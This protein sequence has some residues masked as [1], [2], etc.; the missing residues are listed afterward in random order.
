[1]SMKFPAF[2][3]AIVLL[4]S[5]KPQQNLKSEPEKPFVDKMEFH[6]NENSSLT[7]VVDQAI[8]ENKLIF[9]DIYADWCTPCKMMD[10]DVFS[11]EK[12]EHIYERK[13]C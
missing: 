1:M 8:A 7:S 2:L 11:D 6:H 10:E 9:V 4:I 12:H 3:L 13:L 5:C